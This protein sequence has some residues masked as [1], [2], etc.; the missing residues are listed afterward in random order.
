MEETGVAKITI[1]GVDSE[2][3]LALFGGEVEDYIF[4]LRSYA[5]N[6]PGVLDQLLEPSSENLETF[7]VAV[8]GLK[9]LSRS[10]G[11]TEI[12]DRAFDLE[13]KAKAGKLNEV[14]A[15]YKAFIDDVTILVQNITEWLDGHTDGEE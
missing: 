15:L 6:T 3:G 11:A 14:M 13:L 7:G 2:V 5:A 1:S 8:H 9:S 10:V 4:I 12:A